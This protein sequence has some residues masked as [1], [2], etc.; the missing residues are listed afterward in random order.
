[1]SRRLP[2]ERFS[3]ESGNVCIC[4]RKVLTRSGR[5]IRILPLTKHASSVMGV[6]MSALSQQPHEYIQGLAS[7]LTLARGTG[8]DTRGRLTSGSYPDD[9][10]RTVDERPTQQ[11]DT[12]SP[13]QNRSQFFDRSVH[14]TIRPTRVDARHKQFLLNQRSAFVLACSG[15]HMVAQTYKTV[16]RRKERRF[17]PRHECLILTHM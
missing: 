2:R 15:R 14:G 8:K 3:Q 5:F 1:M 11:G 12:S 10:P 16:K 6:S 13:C 9:A 17:P 4:R 7:L